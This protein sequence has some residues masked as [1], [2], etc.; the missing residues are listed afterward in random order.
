[1]CLRL[2]LI[3]FFYFLLIEVAHTQTILQPEFLTIEEGLSQGFISCLHQDQEG[4]LWVGTKN[5]LNRY[6]GNG[7]EVFTSRKAESRTLSNDWVEDIFEEG[8]FLLISTNDQHLNLLHKQTKRFYHLDLAALSGEKISGLGLIIKDLSGRFWINTKEKQL[9]CLTFSK[10]LWTSSS[11]IDNLL[12]Q[13]EITHFLSQKQSFARLANHQL[14]IGSPGQSFT[15]NL[16]TFEQTKLDRGTLLGD[17]HRYF[18][19]YKGKAIGLG[20]YSIAIKKGLMIYEEN[21]LRWLPTEFHHTSNYF[22]TLTHLLWIQDHPTSDLLLF[23]I[24]SVLNKKEILSRSDASFIIEGFK[25]SIVSWKRDRSGNIWIG[26][27]GFGIAKI[28][29]RLLNIQH[30]FPDQSVYAKPFIDDDMELFQPSLF[31]TAY[32]HSGKFGKLKPLHD[33]I[34]ANKILTHF[35]VQASPEVFW[36]FYRSEIEQAYKMFL[37]RI[38]LNGTVQKV[39]TY[40]HPLSNI[41]QATALAIDEKEQQLLLVLNN[42]LIEHDL[43]THQERDIPINVLPDQFTAIYNLVQT[44]DQNWWLGTS[45]GLVKISRQQ[46]NYTFELFNTDNSGLQNNNCASL[47]LDKV[48]EDILWIGTKGGG[49]HRMN[50]QTM[51]FQY[52]NSEKG[53][54]NDVIYGVLQDESSNLWMSSNKGIIKYNPENFDIKNYLA[55]DGLQNN[56]FNTYAYAQAADGAMA[57]GGINGLNVFHPRDLKDN[58]NAPSVRITKLEVNNQLI[59]PNDSSEILH[60]AIE[61]TE[62]IQLPYSKNSITL[63]FAALEFTTPKKNKY[64]YYIEGKEIPWIHKTADN[65]VSFLNLSPGNHLFKIKAAN[66]DGVWSDEVTTLQI[67]ILPPWYR[68]WWTYLIYIGLLIFGIWELSQIRSR[69]IQL[70]YNMQLEQ[71]ETDRLRELEN[72]RS[73]LYTDITHEFR[74]PLT[75]ILGTADQLNRQSKTKE[76]QQKIHLIQRNGKNLLELINQLLDLAKVEHNELSINYIQGDI[77][78]YIHYLSES[79]HSLAQSRQIKLQ[80]QSPKQEIWMDYDPVKIRQIM[81]NLISNAIKYTSTN[82]KVSINI[83]TPSANQVQIMVSD[84]GQG[85]P[86]KDIARIFDRFYQADDD[87]AKAGGTGIGLALTRELVHLLGGKIG[88]ESQI[89]VGTTFKI[90]LPITKKAALESVEQQAIL[91]SN[92]PYPPKPIVT[93][94]A[95]KE[96]TLLIIEDNADVTAY[97]IACLEKDYNLLFAINGQK[98]IE[99]AIENVPDIIISD[100][101]MPKKTGFEVCETLKADERTSHIPIVLLTAKAD[102]DSRITGLKRGADA[103]LAKPFHEQELA[104]Q[105]QNL[106]Q[107]RKQLQARYQS[108]AHI[109]KTKETAVQLEDAFIE[110][111]RRK[112]EANLQ[113]DEFG[114]NELC[115]SMQMS[116]T[117]LH[118]KLKVLTDRSTSKFIRS[119]RLNKAKQLL[120]ETDLS[121]KEVAFQVGYDDRAYF[122]RVYKG[123]FGVSPKQRS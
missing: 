56:E 78:N 9:I 85:I 104:V 111:V 32:Y 16:T 61:F 51:E 37:H 42:K 20:E 117:Q 120:T 36:I 12:K 35:I 114:I 73:R 86:D 30:L 92:T 57:F 54:P 49:L 33:I 113:N 23:D 115:Q 99:Q 108:L 81:G 5:G 82:G 105:L 50:V 76:N 66:G 100:V 116:R 7:F 18:A 52:L 29:P 71:K 110:R 109:P 55:S 123:E 121:V 74:T 75:V 112:I 13:V 6:D 91:P 107:L 28:N 31:G 1:M 24:E 14:L 2:L 80:L 39:G 84:T 106:L 8:D 68:T 47:L 4:F 22:D 62:S 44:I 72:F 38:D 43:A 60:N 15:L 118:N 94:I 77:F 88:V 103:Y 102:V 27:G 87:I 41:L 58:L 10:Q 101:M 83:D 34:R 26:T 64:S 89:G 59:E 122:S 46:E 70:Q 119:V 45:L 40:E 96:Y 93:Q 17:H 69:R 3:S 95:N 65:R 25:S 48:R 98:G 79:F 11:E 63:E 19:A 67:K 21:E 53:L 90:H 97:L